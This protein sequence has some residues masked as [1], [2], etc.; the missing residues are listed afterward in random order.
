MQQEQRKVWVAAQ[1]SMLNCCVN[2]IQPVIHCRALGRGC[3]ELVEMLDRQVHWLV[4]LSDCKL[5]RVTP[6]DSLLH[7]PLEG[8][9]VRPCQHQR[10]VTPLLHDLADI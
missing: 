3:R 10:V 6:H 9:H 8:D 1:P 5:P 4:C 7:P 2:A